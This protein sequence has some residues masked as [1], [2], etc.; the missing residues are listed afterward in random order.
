[1]TC[2]VTEASALTP[3]LESPIERDLQEGVMVR[4]RPP[5]G[6]AAA[7]SSPRQIAIIKSIRRAV[8]PDAIR[9]TIELDRE[10]LFHEERLDGPAR[11]FVDLSSTRP[12]PPLRDQSLRFDRD[13]DVVR[14][15]RIGRHPNNTTRVVLDAVGVSSYTLYALYSPYRLVI[16]CVR[17]MSAAVVGAG[18]VAPAVGRQEPTLQRIPARLL[19]YDWGR[20]FP[21]VPPLAGPALGVAFLVCRHAVDA[22]ASCA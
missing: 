11:V 18:S 9:I 21:L 8:L 10:V 12:A 19:V 2:T 6:A 5:E 4:P 16:D 22:V 14:Q 15:I 1:D 3:T 20:L 13:G 17:A 7:V